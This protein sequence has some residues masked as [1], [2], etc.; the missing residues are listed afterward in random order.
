MGHSFEEKTFG[1][2]TY[3][4]NCK[5]L[6]WG[7]M[8]Q[9]LQCKDCGY[10]CHRKCVSTAAK[11]TVAP[12]KFLDDSKTDSRAETYLRQLK[13][14]SHS[15]ITATTTTT[16]SGT[17]NKD[18]EPSSSGNNSDK[19]VQ[20]STFK[21]LCAIATSSKF[22]TILADAVINDEEPV[23][24]YLASQAALNPNVTTK[25]FTRFVSR[26]GPVFAFRDELIWLI[27]WKNRVDTFV[28]MVFYC[29]V[30]IYPKLLF[31]IPQTI[32]VYY[33]LSNYP[34]KRTT[35]KQDTSTVKEKAVE[36]VKSVSTKRQA[37]EKHNTIAEHSTASFVFNLSSM[38][39]PSSDDSPEYLK[40]MKN[41]Q[42]MMGEFSDMYDKVMLEAKHFNWSSEEETL[43]VLQAVLA[44]SILLGLILYFIPINM[45]FLSCGLMVYGM[46]TRFTKYMTKEL[47]PYIFQSGK[48]KLEGLKQWYL[49]LEN[50]LKSQEHLKEISVYEN[51]RWWPLRGYLHEMVNCERSPWS[52]FTGAVYMPIIT[53]IPAPKGYQ[54][55]DTSE[56]ALDRTGPWVDDYLGIEIA[57]SPDTD[58]WVYSDDNWNISTTSIKPIDDDT[59][60]QHK[61]AMTRRRRWIRECE[62]I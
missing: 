47:Q 13:Q 51:Q 61:E 15:T 11:C 28:S 33:I 35:V 4:D 24:E 57:T 31:F 18:I 20:D 9:G 10:T 30:C 23:N 52:D 8:K 55:K 58:G 6:L 62:N 22:H 36:P 14:K 16:T 49:T 32:I 5:Q 29:I 17:K 12:G 26:C 42:N 56:W 50:K 34:K 25:N 43:R 59:K 53:E 46:N 27:N 44:S 1:H 3:C 48:R 21:S 41:I 60:E 54:W 45:I 39:Q 7:V 19:T 38:F 40:N 2:L 37:E